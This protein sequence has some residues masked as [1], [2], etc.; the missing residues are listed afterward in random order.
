[1]RLCE[2]E[3]EIGHPRHKGMFLLRELRTGGWLCYIVSLEKW[4]VMQRGFC[5]ENTC[6][7][8]NS[9]LHVCKDCFTQGTTY[10]VL[11]INRIAVSLRQGLQVELRTC[12]HFRAIPS[13]KRTWWQLRG[14]RTR[15]ASN[16]SK[17]GQ[18]L[19]EKIGRLI[20]KEENRGEGKAASETDV[21]RIPCALRM[22]SLC[23][24][25]KRQFEY[26]SISSRGGSKWSSASSFYSLWSSIVSIKDR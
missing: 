4:S 25:N 2:T 13:K 22:Y 7:G 21:H 12:T 19:V 6:A 8:N 23:S 16:A 11:P 15:A 14:Q 9:E 5:D 24:K 17:S 3:S 20:D 26:L 18:I 1:M 10:Q